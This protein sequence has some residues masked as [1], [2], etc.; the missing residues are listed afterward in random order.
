MSVLGFMSVLGYTVHAA[1]VGNKAS[2]VGEVAIK[3]GWV[4]CEGVV[5]QRVLSGWVIGVKEGSS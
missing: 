1:G 2:A 5:V 3:Q 4:D